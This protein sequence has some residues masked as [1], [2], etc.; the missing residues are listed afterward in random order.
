MSTAGP[1][2]A[3][4]GAQRW[5]P[6]LKATEAPPISLVSQVNPSMHML[7]APA[8]A[9]PSRSPTPDPRQTT[10]MVQA[11]AVDRKSS[12]MISEA[13]TTAYLPLQTQV[14]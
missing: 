7:P 5:Q 13:T 2:Q 3:E 9:Y 1:F 6:I 14:A 10:Y 11:I 12:A 4:V 8:L